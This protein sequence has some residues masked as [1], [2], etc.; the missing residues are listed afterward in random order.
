MKTLKN[1]LWLI[2]LL[3]SLV[4]S[5]KFTIE[6]KEPVALKN[7]FPG[8]LNFVEVLPGKRREDYT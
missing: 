8:S 1:S 7:T 4:F 3:I 5:N 2:G 6:I